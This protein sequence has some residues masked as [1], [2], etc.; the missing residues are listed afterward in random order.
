MNLENGEWQDGRTSDSSSAN[1]ARGTYDVDYK[2]LDRV[3]HRLATVRWQA[4][5]VGNSAAA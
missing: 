1:D 5:G 3:Q 2:E 4:S